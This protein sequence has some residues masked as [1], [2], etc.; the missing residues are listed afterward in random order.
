[1]GFDFFRQDDERPESLKS[2][3]SDKFNQN[4]MDKE[5][6][7]FSKKEESKLPKKEELEKGLQEAAEG[8]INKVDTEELK[9]EAIADKKEE[10]EELIEDGASEKEVKAAI[11]EL[12]AL[13]GEKSYKI[14]AEAKFKHKVDGNEVEVGLQE[15]LNNFSGKQA[16]DKKF[17]ELDKDR[18]SYK[19]ELD[20]VNKY[21][22]EFA[23]ISKKDKVEGLLRLAEAVGI[24]PYEYKKQ[25]RNE[26]AEKFNEYLG[27]NEYQRELYELKE[28]NEYLLRRR[29]AEEKR[30]AD[31]QA[32][33]ERKHQMEQLQSNLKIDDDRL[34]LIT[35]ELTNLKMDI[36]PRNIEDVHNT[37]V[38]LDRVDSALQYVNPGLVENNEVVLQLEGF[39]K[40]KPN[41]TDE[42]LKEVAAK[43]W[44][45]ETKKAVANAEKK[46][47]KREISTP[48]KPLQYEPKLNKVG[49]SLNFFD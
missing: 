30:K 6:D 1:M 12:E 28:Q 27:M 19:K 37:L 39:L 8:K 10:I 14:P 17:S 11:K 2:D 38:R 20:A 47:P 36:N 43:L 3:N 26:F 25:L 21:V 18:S 13:Y 42:E 33:L 23:E 4:E 7:F 34:N 35:G 22:N 41:M 40:S 46:A 5:V 24:D 16:W 15:L 32:E 48:K 31:A 45:S 44:G 29:E 9:A 49:N